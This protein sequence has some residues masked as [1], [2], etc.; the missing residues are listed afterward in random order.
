MGCLRSVGC[1]R[2]RHRR[3]FRDDATRYITDGR[4][5]LERESLATSGAARECYRYNTNAGRLKD[6]ADR[7]GGDADAGERVETKTSNNRGVSRRA[8]KVGRYSMPAPPTAIGIDAAATDSATA[9]ES[10]RLSRS[11][12][13]EDRDEEERWLDELLVEPGWPAY[14][15][16]ASNEVDK[17]IL[18]RTDRRTNGR[19]CRWKYDHRKTSYVISTDDGVV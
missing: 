7:D 15:R 13:D 16:S 10:A 12:D 11:R 6:G 1:L 19:R 5:D 4:R 8:R 17:S 9:L 3:V 2:R 18:E 14:R